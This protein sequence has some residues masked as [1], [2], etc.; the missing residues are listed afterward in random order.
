MGK[1]RRSDGCPARYPD[2]HYQF[3]SGKSTSQFCS[4]RGRVE[5]EKTA[6]HMLSSTVNLGNGCSVLEIR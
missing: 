2:E 6:E 5:W 3:G 4:D 1:L